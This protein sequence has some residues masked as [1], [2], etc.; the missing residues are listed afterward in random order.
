MIHIFSLIF[1]SSLDSRRNKNDSSQTQQQQQLRNHPL[2]RFCI[3]AMAKLNKVYIATLKPKLSV[4]YSHPLTGD[5]NYL[6]LLSWQLVPIVQSGS[7]GSGKKGGD[8]GGGGGSRTVM[9]PVLAFAK[10]NTVYLVQAV[11]SSSSSNHL[12]RQN[13]NSSSTS[14]SS[15]AESLRFSLLQTISLTYNLTSLRWFNSRTLALMDIHERIHVV[16]AKSEEELEAVCHSYI[17]Y[18]SQI[19]F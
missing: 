2:K 16:D 13:S 1:R 18:Y 15:S 7:G 19:M 10:E 4:V 17:S 11:S 14:S 6:P 12:Q 8:G 5:P 9:E 3:V